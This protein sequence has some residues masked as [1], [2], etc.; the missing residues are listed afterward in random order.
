MPESAAQQSLP[1]L[2][3]VLRLGGFRRL[4][5]VRLAGQFADGLL[6]VGLASFV[7]FSPERAA[8]PGRVALGFAVLLLPFSLV[9]PFA[10]VLLDRW[11]RRQVL[12]V[13][14]LTRAVGVAL[15]ALLIAV[16]QDGAPLYVTALSVLGVNRFVLA[17]LGASLPHV[18]STELL[19][20][21]NAVAPTA[22]TAM[23]FVGAG[24]G[25][26]LASGLGGGD[27]ADASVICLGAAACI[28]AAGLATRLGRSQLGP[29]QPA[30][31]SLHSAVV[32]VVQGF[33]AGVGHVRDAPR[34]ARALTVMGGHRFLFG[35]ATVLSIVLFRNTFYPNDAKA[36]LTALGLSLACGGAGAVSGAVLTPGA[37][38][39]IGP[40]RW[41]CAL[42]LLAALDMALLV[43]WF[44][45]PLFLAASFLI[46]LVAQGVKVTIDTILQETIDDPYRGRVFTLYD[47]VFNAS[48]VLAGAV[49]A[50]VVPADGRSLAFTTAIAVGYALLATWY[51]RISREDSA[52]PT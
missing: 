43:S 22:G 17:A 25:I 7:F 26:A 48:F 8:T 11:S 38:R 35:L 39:R 4:L 14:N 52:D 3:A 10:G 19:V 15:I 2:R 49:A 16:G 40:T 20:T 42:L 46:G 44:R 41:I 12:V 32:D 18:V 36:A 29:D 23:T 28:V 33:V 31:V 1:G 21:A 45:E 50:L 27:A 5:A 37:T 30:D 47:L 6:Q 13:A 9:G 24:L 34:A 51:Q